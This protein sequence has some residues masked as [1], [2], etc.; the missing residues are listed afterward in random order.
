MCY[1]RII[2]QT[3]LQFCRITLFPEYYYIIDAYDTLEN[4]MRWRKEV[5]ERK[6]TLF[7]SDLTAELG[8][9]EGKRLRQNLGL[10]SLQV[11]LG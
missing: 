10:W 11:D 3:R 7:N 5:L 2:S 6:L 8:K 4:P 9:H 1:R